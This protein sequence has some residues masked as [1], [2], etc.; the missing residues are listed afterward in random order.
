MG[1][2]KF[3]TWFLYNLILFLLVFF[4]GK[5]AMMWSLPPLNSSPIWPPIGITVAFILL[6]GRDK[7]FGAFIGAIL[8]AL[9][10]DNT[11]IEAPLL[12][13]ASGGSILFALVA[14][15]A[16]IY[17]FE[18]PRREFLV[19][20]DI[21]L[22]LL[23]TGP[24][25]GFFTSSWGIA[26]Y[27]ISGNLGTEN[28]FL[29]WMTWFIGDS[30]G[31]IIFCPLA[32]IFSKG[33]RA[34]WMRS[35][36]KIVVPLLFFFFLILG[37]LHYVN[38]IER[39][40]VLEEFGRRSQL[41]L[42]LL[43]QGLQ[44]HQ[45]TINALKSF[46]E[47]SELITPTE[48]HD[49]TARLYSNYPEIQ[50]VAF[51]KINARGEITAEHVYSGGKYPNSQLFRSLPL[52][53]A[54]KTRLPHQ[55]DADKSTD[56]FSYGP[57]EVAVT[58]RG[59]QE[60][61]ISGRSAKD[62][63]IIEVLNLNVLSSSFA[64]FFDDERY[65]YK[66]EDITNPNHPMT[67]FESIERDDFEEGTSFFKKVSTFKIA[68]RTLKATISQANTLSSDASKGIAVLLIASLVLTYLTSALL[69]IFATR[70][71]SVNK[72]VLQNT[73]HL[74]ELN[75]KLIRASQAKSEFLA[76]MSHEIRTPLHVLLG[77]LKVLDSENLS[78]EDARFLNLAE[79]AGDNLLNTLNEILDLSKIESG[80]IEI[81]N[82]DVNIQDVAREVFELFQ[83]QAQ[84]KGLELSYEVAPQ[85]AKIYSGDPNRIKQVLSNLVS[86]AIKFTSQGRIDIK[87]ERNQEPL[88]PGNIYFAIKDTGVGISADNIQHLFQ[89][90]SQADSSIARRFGG[91]GLGLSICKMLTELMGGDI[92]VESSEGQGSTF[93][94]TLPLLYR[95][96]APTHQKKFEKD[97]REDYQRNILPLRILIADDSEDNRN[98]IKAYLKGVEHHIYEV[99]NGQEAVDF[100]K[101]TPLDLIIMDVQMPVLDG[102]KATEM[103]RSWEKEQGDKRHV[104]VWA[105][106]AFA[107]ESEIR[108]TLEAGCDKHL[109]KP[110]SRAELYKSLYQLQA[111]IENK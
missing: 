35:F 24:I 39:E 110:V 31:G 65:R 83:L 56:Q 58:G 8:I 13:L 4:S 89:P 19:E 96:D 93:S 107:L 79:K 102:L 81:E 42:R 20:R 88:R 71:V 41:S 78:E 111:D 28:L 26:C 45:M 77:S 94:F 50:F 84:E 70:F 106:T 40:K 99:Q 64:H 46:I 87:I 22:F 67:I 7:I 15:K 73:L 48:F 63:V 75:S 69:L 103:I 74:Q 3:G 53:D 12:A 95:S 43:E 30:I 29:N 68:Q 23:I 92:R 85:V 9:S 51:V 17:R 98:L 52:S 108:Q 66:L 33:A 47:N 82:I 34:Y 61:M 44:F 55:N 59:L 91:T 10:G 14:A 49:F 5:L 27:A 100:V 62:G 86:N 104:Q 37:A 97:G 76:N 36:K 101:G 2:N 25:L 32:L 1:K 16:V 60:Y 38:S 90:F 21:L 11:N 80:Q 6:F 57:V 105:I 72:L 54:I 18:Y 109:A